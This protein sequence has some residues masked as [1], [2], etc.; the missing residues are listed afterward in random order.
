MSI[1]F[2]L[3]RR[4]L[5]TAFDEAVRIQEDVEAPAESVLSD[6]TKTLAAS[7]NKVLRGQ[8]AQVASL[9]AKVEA[10]ESADE[11]GSS[12]ESLMMTL[13]E[14]VPGFSVWQTNVHSRTEEMDLIVLNGSQ[15]AVFS[16]D[17]PIILI[18][19][20]NWTA[21]TGRPEFSILEG[22]IRNRH[23]RCTIAFLVSWAGFTETTW[24]ETLRL[25]REQYAVICLDGTDIRSAALTGNF[26]EFLRQKTI[27]MLTS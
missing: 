18:E 24:L 14:Q 20:K 9:V 25:S 6:V 15:D 23:G 10:A 27:A 21:K 12:L 4:D 2:Q 1:H 3:V 22:K 11:K 19:C 13:F 7:A 5:K 17:G 16:K 26:P 8:Y